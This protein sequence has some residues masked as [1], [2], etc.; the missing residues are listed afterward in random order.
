MTEEVVYS[1]GG[2]SNVF[3]KPDP[4]TDAPAPRCEYAG[5]ADDGR[6][7]YIPRENIERT[8]RPCKKCY[9]QIRTKD[10]PADE[11]AALLDVDELSEDIADDPSALRTLMDENVRVRAI[12]QAIGVGHSTLYNRLQTFGIETPHPEC[13]QRK[14]R[15][16][17]LQQ[18][19]ENADADDIGAATP[20]GDDDW[21]HFYTEGEK[22]Q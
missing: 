19:L 13:S 6:W 17:E 9:S 1:L 2:S 8:R 4:D 16:G 22:G 5:N 21:Q 7:R 14:S 3:H 18:A 20:N 11:I 12:S 10:L 15:G